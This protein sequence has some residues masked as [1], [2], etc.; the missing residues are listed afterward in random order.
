MARRRTLS[1]IC[2]EIRQ[3]SRHLTTQE[4]NILPFCL[5]CQEGI[6]D[7]SLSGI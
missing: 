6:F 7:A 3:L 1:K 4:E 2:L 5:F